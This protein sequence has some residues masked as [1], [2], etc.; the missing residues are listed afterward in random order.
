MGGVAKAVANLF[1]GG[2]VK[3]AER[4]QRA[5]AREIAK[6]RA[7]QDAVEAGL[8]RANAG[9]GFLGY[10]DEALKDTLG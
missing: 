8:R 3:K 7:R 4:E 10:V 9:G 5:Q 1:T 2:A 6:Q